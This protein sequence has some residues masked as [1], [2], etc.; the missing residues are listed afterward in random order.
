MKYEMNRL[1]EKR[2]KK[3]KCDKLEYLE[4]KLKEEMGN[5]SKVKKRPGLER[6]NLWSLAIDMSKDETKSPEERKVIGMLCLC[7]HLIENEANGS[8]FL[9]RH[10]VRIN[11]K[12]VC[13]SLLYVSFL[14]HGK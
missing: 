3:L 13:G 7:F 6:A 8:L 14:P 12:I 1:T 5:A 10:R 2:G 9:V 11:A 4:D